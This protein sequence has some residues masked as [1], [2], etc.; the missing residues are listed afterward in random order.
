MKITQYFED[1]GFELLYVYIKGINRCY[2]DNY[3]S[4]TNINKSLY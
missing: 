2:K 3:F 1:N 4:F